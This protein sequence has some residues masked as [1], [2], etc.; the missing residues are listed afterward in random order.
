MGGRRKLSIFLA[1]LLVS[2]H[3]TWPAHAASGV[4]PEMPSI[5]LVKEAGGALVPAPPLLTATSSPLALRAL[6]RGVGATLGVFRGPLG[7]VYRLLHFMFGISILFHGMSFKTLAFHI[8]VFRLSGIKKVSKHWTDLSRH[9]LR[10]RA[11]M[12]LAAQNTQALT[13]RQKEQLRIKADRKRKLLQDRAQLL[14]DQRITR[15]EA[16]EFLDEYRYELAIM[17]EEQENLEAATS[18]IRALFSAVKWKEVL[19]TVNQLYSSLVLT[20][21]AS[22]FKWAGRLSMGI[23]CGQVLKEDVISAIGPRIDPLGYEAELESY[24]IGVMTEPARIAATIVSI[25]F[26]TGLLFLFHQDPESALRVCLCFL[27]S[28]IVTDHVLRNITQHFPRLGRL[29]RLNHRRHVSNTPAST[30]L[31]WVLALIGYFLHG[32]PWEPISALCLPFI[33]TLKRIDFLVRQFK[34]LTVDYFT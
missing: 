28:N 3:L 2:L 4:A 25:F 20:L 32:R 29:L 1:L 24:I 7:R 11:A 19:R 22:T 10:A 27:G 33:F 23:Y 18:S 5:G 34:T 6:E 26:T 30:V 16:R 21:T 12:E 31:H 17:R 8:I 15:D 9:Y 14:R 13:S